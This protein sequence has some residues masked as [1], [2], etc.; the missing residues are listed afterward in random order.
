MRPH[1]KSFL[2]LSCFYAGLVVV[3]DFLLSEYA[4]LSWLA[5]GICFVVFSVLIFDLLLAFT[6]RQSSHRPPSVKLPEDELE[7]LER[8]VINAIRGD[9]EAQL[10][11]SKRLQAI[12]LRSDRGGSEAPGAGHKDGTQV[13][14]LTSS[15]YVELNQIA[16]EPKVNRDL[17]SGEW[18]RK[19]ERLLGILESWKY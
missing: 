19:I 17:G 18:V 14:M 4:I 11:I 15:E 2:E 1:A 16:G 7:R 10:T 12:L 5:L 6:A 3:L 13:E 8:V 9:P